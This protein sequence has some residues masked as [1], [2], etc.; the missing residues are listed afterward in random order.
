MRG[1][2]RVGF[3]VRVGVRVGGRVR[4]SPTAPGMIEYIYIYITGGHERRAAPR[5]GDVLE[6]AGELRERGHGH[7]SLLEVGRLEGLVKVRVRV[8]VGLGSA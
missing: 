4:V 1:R 5:G 3:G 7:G 6:A 2:V 8:R